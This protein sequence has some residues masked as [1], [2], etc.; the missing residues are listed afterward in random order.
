MT[1]DIIKATFAVDFAS[2]VR[3]A[4]HST[5]V[6]R[7]AVAPTVSSVFPLA[8]FELVPIELPLSCK[9][10]PFV[11]GQGLLA[12]VVYC[13]L[14]SSSESWN[15]L[16]LVPCEQLLPVI[17]RGMSHHPWHANNSQATY[18]VAFS[19]CLCPAQLSTNVEHF[20]T[21]SL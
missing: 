4:H 21:T 8:V 11:V 6:G 5:N 15:A 12:L 1:I 18:C 14:Y 9:Q 7:G 16:I 3:C 2:F 19:H 10:C 17:G 13:I 20:L